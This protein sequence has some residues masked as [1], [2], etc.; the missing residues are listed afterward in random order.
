MHLTAA[1]AGISCFYERQEGYSV[2][3]G[4]DTLQLSTFSI[5]A[6]HLPAVPV[7]DQWPLQHSAALP[8]G[9]PLPEQQPLWHSAADLL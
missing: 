3:T 8:A 4:A 9:M 1:S 2:H 7:A 5:H 6:C